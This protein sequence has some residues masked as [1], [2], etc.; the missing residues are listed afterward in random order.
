M[1]TQLWKMFMLMAPAG[2]GGGGGG[3]DPPKPIT[4]DDLKAVLDARD[5]DLDKKLNQVVTAHLGR[6]DFKAQLAEVLKD[7]EVVKTIKGD[8]AGGGGGDKGKAGEGKLDAASEARIKA[9]EKTAS[10]AKKAADDWK[11]KVELAEAKAQ[12]QEERQLLSTTLTEAKVAPGRLSLA[13]SHLSGRIVRDK[14]DP[15]KILWKEDD[16]DPVP[17]KDGFAEYQKSAE[18]KELLPARDVGGSG[19]G[20]GGQGGGGSG[21]PGDM[22]DSDLV[23]GI[24]GG[25]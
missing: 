6:I 14:E 8:D 22:S 4:A 17:Y 15:T 9:A 7:P 23:R 13:I 24:F 11:A 20:G 25:G 19:N 10:E 18:F 21:K 16:K 12:R 3:G 2:D 5:K 1:K